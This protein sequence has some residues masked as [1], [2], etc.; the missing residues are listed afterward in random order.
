MPSLYKTAAEKA[1][2]AAVEKGFAKE[3]TWW[4]H[5][6]TKHRKKLSAG[7]VDELSCFVTL[8][9]LCSLDACNDAL[10][11][12][13][14]TWP[15]GRSPMSVDE[16]VLTFFDLCINCWVE[17]AYGRLFD[18]VHIWLGSKGFQFP[19]HEHPENAPCAEESVLKTCD[20]TVK[21]IEDKITRSNSRYKRSQGFVLHTVAT[22]FKQSITQERYWDVGLPEVVLPDESTYK[23]ALV[24]QR[25]WKDELTLCNCSNAA[26]PHR[27]KPTVAQFKYFTRKVKVL[28]VFA[29]LLHEMGVLKKDCYQLG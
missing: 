13:Q 5:L 14:K 3:L 25:V 12:W 24:N 11:Q 23:G 26:I 2:Q 10:E 7:M 6:K 21:R 29:V 9:G 20:V 1:Q 16:L 18:V 22:W 17:T 15:N 4:A 28:I 27:N 8:D 19:F